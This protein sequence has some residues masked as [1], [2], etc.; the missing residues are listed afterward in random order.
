MPAKRMEKCLME[1]SERERTTELMIRRLGDIR[2]T[3]SKVAGIMQGLTEDR[4]NR[5]QRYWL[6]TLKG[7]GDHVHLLSTELVMI[8]T[9]LAKELSE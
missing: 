6:N 1:L 7:W 4:I 3:L 9:H 2:V 8:Q 5:N